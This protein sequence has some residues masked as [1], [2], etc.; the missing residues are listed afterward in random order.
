MADQ[1]ISAMPSASTLTGAELVP[2][3]QSGANVKATLSTMS[4]FTR[5]NAG[6]WESTVS[7]T[8]STTAGTAFTFNQTDFSGGITLASSTRMTVPVNGTYNLQFSAQLQNLDTAP[9]DVYVWI[10]INGTD[11]AGSSGVIG[12]PA[13]KN[14]GDPFHSIYGW[15]Y[16]LTLTAGQYV[17]LI[18][19]PTST[20]VSVPFYS[21]QT[22]PAI[23]STAS[24]IAT[25]CQVA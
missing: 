23:P 6:A 25:M 21:A 2:L 9:Q 10:R 3:V 12:L 11:F 17:E 1:K 18:W 13:R 7:Q 16:Y 5:G 4:A 8:G 19:L 14:P 22:S 20:N 24:I 15:N